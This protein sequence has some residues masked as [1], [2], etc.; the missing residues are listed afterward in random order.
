V[1]NV[2]GSINVKNDLGGRLEAGLSGRLHRSDRADL[3][4][5]TAVR[6]EVCCGGRRG[7]QCVD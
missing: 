2:G 4:T 6:S 1:V 5:G 3:D 7:R